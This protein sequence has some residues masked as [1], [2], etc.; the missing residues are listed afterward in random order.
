MALVTMN[1]Q[2]WVEGY[3]D[4]GTG[5]GSLDPSLTKTQNSPRCLS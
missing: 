2:Y 3:N 4:I 1:E 5:A